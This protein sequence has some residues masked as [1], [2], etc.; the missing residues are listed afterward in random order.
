MPELRK[1]PI[2]GRWVIVSTERARRPDQFVGQAKDE[3]KQSACPFC[4]GKESQTPP[5]IYAVRPHNPAPNGPG[6]DLRVIPSI[7]PFLRVEGDLERRGNGV[8]D[9]MN[10]VGAHEVIIETNQHIAN[11]AD[12]SQ[13]QIVRV[14]NCY[15][16]RIMDL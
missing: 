15:S 8:Y 4:E 3:D 16:D 9:V 12:L 7:S 14:L 10:G 1:D 11:M 2:I 6:W 5:E 13:E